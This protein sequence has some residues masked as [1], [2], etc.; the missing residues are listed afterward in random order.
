MVM[1]LKEQSR[2]KT[3]ERKRKIEKKE[4]KSVPHSPCS[5]SPPSAADTRL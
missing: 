4:K 3:D 2:P 1:Q 5:A